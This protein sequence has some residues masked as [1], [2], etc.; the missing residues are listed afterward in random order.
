V[1]STWFTTLAAIR[2]A[3]PDWAEIACYR[4]PIARFLGRA[5]PKLSGDLRDDVVQEV[6]CAMHGSAVARFRPERGRFRHYLRGVIRNHVRKAL[7]EHRALPPSLAEEPGVADEVID[8]ESV[9]VIDLQACL[10]R[11]VRDFH[12]EVLRG[13]PDQRQVLY[14]LSGRLIDQL[15]YAE[16]AKKE[17][18]SRDA[19]KRRL[20]SAR[21]GILRALVRGALEDHGQA[22][23]LE[24]K[25]L[26]RLADRVGEALT[27]RRPADEILAERGDS[28]L[29][30]A[31]HPAAAELVLRFREGVRWFPGLDSPDGQAFASALSGILESRDP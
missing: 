4:E 23:T 7:R 25:D 11:A 3:Q 24:T 30:S 28:P 12:D 8:A 1:A 26:S 29:L 22:D 31:C 10:V 9:E 17:G 18:I 19:V 13:D 21:R 2:E 16:I 14:C 20:Q 27:S 15:S 6:L 5:Y